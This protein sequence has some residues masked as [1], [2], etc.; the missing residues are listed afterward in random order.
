MES[1]KDKKL[2]EKAERL[3][4][5]GENPLPS[6]TEGAIFACIGSLTLSKRLARKYLNEIIETLEEREN[7]Q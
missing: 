4:Y 2:I 6:E 7:E 5:D 3:L 1:T